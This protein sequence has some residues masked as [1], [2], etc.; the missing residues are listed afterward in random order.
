MKRAFIAALIIAAGIIS[1][2]SCK[3]FSSKPTAD[4]SFNIQGKWIVDSMEN[5]SSDSSKSIV[6]LAFVLA[7][8][9]SLPFGFQFNNDSTYTYLSA[10]D[11]AVGKYYI[12]DEESTLFVAEDSAYHPLNFI[13]KNDS[14]FSVISADSLVLHLRKEK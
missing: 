13:S 14:A 12:A 11:S 9:D 7:A 5:R 8:N 6:M 10:K 3:W 2:V 4:Q 1:F